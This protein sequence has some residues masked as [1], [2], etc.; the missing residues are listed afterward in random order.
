MIVSYEAR[1]EAGEQPKLC[2][3]VTS[4]D[5]N[6]SVVT[7]LNLSNKDE[8]PNIEDDLLWEH[9]SNLVDYM[10]IV[11]STISL[12]E[13]GM[14]PDEG[15]PVLGWTDVQKIN[16]EITTWWAYM[17]YREEPMEVIHNVVV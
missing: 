6:E 4:D 9:M 12:V 10:K 15:W 8:V 14:S 3:V 16:D 17:T 7:S 2:K 11:V 1:C 5:G 13:R